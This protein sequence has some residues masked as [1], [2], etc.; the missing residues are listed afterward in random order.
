M[1]NRG[2]PKK[3]DVRNNNCI[4]RMSEQEVVMLNLLSIETG[5]S[6]S[7]ILRKGL[8]MQYKLWS[9]T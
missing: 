9:I 8:E 4:V 1:E 5:Q 7:D 6:K 3:E 2:R